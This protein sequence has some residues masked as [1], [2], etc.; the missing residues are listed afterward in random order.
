MREIQIKKK[1][2]SSIAKTIQFHYKMMGLNYD[3]IFK[4]TKL[5]LSI[6]KSVC[7]ETSLR[8][9]ELYEQLQFESKRLD[10][11][12][13]FLME[14]KCET[15]KNKFISRISS[16]FKTNWLIDIIS[17]ANSHVYKYPYNGRLYADIISTFYMN[18]IE[19][20]ES[21]M[22]DV[23][24]LERTNYYAKKKEAIALLGYCIWGVV[25][26]KYKKSYKCSDEDVEIDIIEKSAYEANLA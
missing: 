1:N 2:N 19:H 7:W 5:L 12:L 25:I 24:N 4:K 26:P 21:D 18:Y 20:T 23:L 15:D 11:A 10:V 22:L 9:D 3:E 17:E 14:Y 8:A 6:Y 16:F 13:E